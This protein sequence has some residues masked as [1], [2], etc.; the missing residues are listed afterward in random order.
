MT[1]TE[2]ETHIRQRYNAVGDSFFTQAEIFNNIY[3]AQVELATETYCIKNVYNTS[4]VASQRVYDFPSLAIVP[5]RVE[6]NGKRIFPS[7]FIDDD[8][9]TGN[10]PGSTTTGTP[11]HYQ[12]WGQEIYLRPIPSTAVTDGIKIFSA[13]LPDTVTAVSTLDVPTRYHLFLVDFVLYCMFAKEKNHVMANHH[14]EIW[15]KNKEKVIAIEGRRRS[16]DNLAIVKDSA[17]IDNESG[18]Y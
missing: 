1:P 18:F 8:A 10:N 11:E 6:Y 17:D 2:L 13:D 7:D 3:A 14:Y 5:E 16:A 15:L 12:V 4:S 9:L